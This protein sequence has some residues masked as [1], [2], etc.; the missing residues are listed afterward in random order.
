M[1]LRNSGNLQGKPKGGGNKSLK[2][3]LAKSKM[4]QNERIRLEVSQPNDQSSSRTP[5]RLS[6]EGLNATE[7]MAR[8]IM[9]I[10]SKFSKSKMRFYKYPGFI[11]E[12]EDLNVSLRSLKNTNEYNLHTQNV[13]EPKNVQDFA[14]KLSTL[15]FTKLRKKYAAPL[16]SDREDN[17][18][19][20]TPELMN[21]TSRGGNQ[22][23][24][25]KEK[26]GNDTDRNEKRN[27]FLKG[28]LK[29][30]NAAS[31]KDKLKHPTKGKIFDTFK[32]KEPNTTR[33]GDKSESNRDGK[34][35]QKNDNTW[36]IKRKDLLLKYLQDSKFAMD[37][38]KP[39]KAI[40]GAVTH[41]TCQ[42]GYLTGIKPVKEASLNKTKI[43]TESNR[44]SEKR[45]S[46]PSS[47]QIKKKRAHSDDP[48]K[49]KK[50]SSIISTDQTKCLNAY[51][52]IVRPTKQYSS[53]SSR[54]ISNNSKLKPR[55]KI[56]GT[57]NDSTQRSTSKLHKKETKQ[58]STE[59]ANPKRDPE[60]PQPKPPTQNPSHH[61]NNKQ[62]FKQNVTTKFTSMTMLTIK[63]KQAV[64][65]HQT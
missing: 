31:D 55:K 34:S 62:S 13:K 58:S 64:K 28:F 29:R 17:S 60:E 65:I 1:N 25:V 39:K 54:P 12:N 14:S 37:K 30:V 42:S 21:K 43:V 23:R 52:P 8:I 40:S 10:E 6:S 33:G 46:I 50:I 53:L 51:K 49:D 2:S 56:R 20:C 24:R 32:K 45:K 41:R 18:R 16:K 27:P 35:L 48:K 38:L 3:S 36:D 5:I 19:A 9:E 22:Q 57:S 4:F 63:K 26:S 15:D 59:R 47:I 61:P 11:S 44:I 7:G